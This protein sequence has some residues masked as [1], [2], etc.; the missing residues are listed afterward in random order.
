MLPSGL[1][2]GRSGF[3]VT[4]TTATVG[5]VPVLVAGASVARDQAWDDLGANTSVEVS[6]PIDTLL[7]KVVS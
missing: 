4:S 1:V 6:V 7:E 5:V 2:M 3:P